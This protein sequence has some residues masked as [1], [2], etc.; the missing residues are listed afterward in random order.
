MSDLIE[1]VVVRPDSLI[2]SDFVTDYE[3]HVSPTRCAIFD[4]GK[5]SRINAIIGIRINREMD[6]R[7]LAMKD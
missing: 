5:T 3:V 6:N 2:D 1:S 4:A 7:C